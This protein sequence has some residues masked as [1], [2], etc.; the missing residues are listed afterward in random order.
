[1]G[2][3][4]SMYEIR[5]SEALERG[6]R[7]AKVGT[8]GFLR[9]FTSRWKEEPRRKTLGEEF[10]EEIEKTGDAEEA[11]DKFIK[12]GLQHPGSSKERVK[13]Y[14]VRTFLEAKEEGRI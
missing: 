1:M 7:P 3:G 13:S 5:L 6:R 10:L 11:L 4:M 2:K 8:S 9:E 14:L 12:R